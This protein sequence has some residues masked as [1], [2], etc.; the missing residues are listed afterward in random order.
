MKT[1]N[2]MQK[3]AMFHRQDRTLVRLPCLEEVRQH[4]CLAS[5]RPSGPTVFKVLPVGG[6]EEILLIRGCWPKTVSVMKT[7]HI[8]TTPCQ[9]ST[10]SISEMAPSVVS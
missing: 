2:K 9:A 3:L 8:R 10:S 1:E 7:E 5:E 6:Q 4:D